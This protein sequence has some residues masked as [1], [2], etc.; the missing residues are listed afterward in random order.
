MQ[1]INCTY[2]G[3]RARYYVSKPYPYYTADA[4][5]AGITAL[6]GTMYSGLVELTAEELTVSVTPLTGEL[7][8]ILNTYNASTG[9][10]DG[11]TSVSAGNVEQVTTQVTPL[12]GTL[13]QVL[14]S[15]TQ[16]TEDAIVS[17]LSVSNGTL[18]QVLI[19]H[20]QPTEAIETTI[21]ALNGTLV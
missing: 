9:A 14:F 17:S 6:D 12:S 4:M 1:I 3:S 18:V 13:V 5:T 10:I 20:S 16:P 2:R 11:S 21:T 7:R 19:T 15:H 8:S